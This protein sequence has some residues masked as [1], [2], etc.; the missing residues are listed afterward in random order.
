MR[1]RL[2]TAFIVIAMA[3]AASAQQA[4]PA[5][6]VPDDHPWVVSVIHS[7]DLT[8][9]V[10]RMR[11]EQ[12]LRIGVPGS[13]P[14]AIYN[15]TTGLVIDGDGHVITRLVNWNPANKNQTISITSQGVSA[16]AHLIGVDCATGFAILEAPSLKTAQPANVARPVAR[17]AKVTIYGTDLV[18]KQASPQTNYQISLAPVITTLQGQVGPDSIYSKARGTLTLV[19]ESFVAR[20]DSSIVTTADNQIIGVA[21]Y[22]GFGRAYLFPFELLRDVVAKRVI[23]QRDNV[24]A[25]WLGT[26]GTGLTKLSLDELGSLGVESKA[27]VIIREVIP[28]SPAAAAG[29]AANDVI[30]MFDDLKVNGEADLRLM[31]SSSPAGRAVKLHVIR[32]RQ[33]V[34]VS[35]VLGARPFSPPVI[36]FDPA[37]QETPD[38]F[39]KMVG[40]EQHYE[41]LQKVGT[42]YQSKPPS[43]ERD[44]GL[45]NITVQS[46]ET[47]AELN[48]L[49]VNSVAV[50]EEDVDVVF[51]GGF[52]GRD[53]T[54]Q[55]AASR[56]AQGVWVSDVRSGSPA[57]RAGLTANDVILAAQEQETPDC[58]ALLKVLSGAQGRI[59]LKVMHE[60]QP[61]LIAFDNR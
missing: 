17:G 29:L 25:G 49:N 32:D 51:A 5:P 45:R 3:A 21:Q 56:G 2:G 28:Q 24:L 4:Q 55:F 42:I 30:V 59:S 13:G 18:L 58:A 54:K 50:R 14:Q 15:V 1:I 40:L 9:V 12:Q 26:A 7:T 16:P 36:E 39:Q 33:P 46:Q 48:R 47:L 34:D 53:M 23:A 11:E 52:A 35:V 43:K 6:N 61:L 19:S 10:A 57:G 44:L 41:D 22:A 60:R 20:Y 31:L 27:G 37:A 8:E 38:K